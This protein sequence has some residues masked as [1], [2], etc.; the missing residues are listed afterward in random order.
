MSTPVVA[1]LPTHWRETLAENPHWIVGLTMQPNREAEE[2][3]EV[4][5]LR[6]P[7]PES[8]R[9][10][11]GPTEPSGEEAGGNVYDA[12]PLL[13]DSGTFWRCKHGATGYA[14]GLEW[15]GCA[16][17]AEERFALR[18]A[19]A[20]TTNAK[21]TSPV[22]DV[23]TERGAQQRRFSPAG[24]PNPCAASHLGDVHKELLAH[25]RC[26]ECNAPLTEDMDWCE[27]RN[28]LA[29]VCSM[30]CWERFAA[31]YDAPRSPGEGEPVLAYGMKDAR[32]F[33][34]YVDA[35]GASR[36]YADVFA[37][38]YDGDITAVPLVAARTRA[39]GD[40]E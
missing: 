17:C 38:G 9:V 31:R 35:G 1:Y 22:P 13:I 5:I 36:H 15:I 28:G 2:W 3:E 7:A 12:H 26:F 24:D 32:G 19:D 11:E 39:P 27:V 16:P 29:T 8:P 14:G 6:A 18:P 30:A 33:F 10:P 25:E 4:E 37:P 20:P 21:G 23:E 40:G 34:D